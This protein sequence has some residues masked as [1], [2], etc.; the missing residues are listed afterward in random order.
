MFLSHFFALQFVRTKQFRQLFK[1]LSETLGETLRARGEDISQI[2]DYVELDE[3]ELK[4]H[5]IRSVLKSNQYAPYFLNKSWVL[6]RSTKGHPCYISDNPITL[7]N[8]VDLGPYGNIGL[9]VQGIEIYFPLSKSLVLGMF[10]KSHEKET[11]KA[12]E[13]YK[14]LKNIASNDELK[15]FGDIPYI[16]HIMDGFENKATVPYEVE[17][18]INHNSLQVYYSSRFVFSSKN[19]FSLAKKM[20]RDNPKIRNGPKM[21]AN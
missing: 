11:R 4:L 8:S 1:D 12:Y 7:Q 18:V 15:S 13:Q 16:S 17:S 2:K 19:D 6:F 3:G 10:C 14:F 20:I 5:G 9:A 21:V